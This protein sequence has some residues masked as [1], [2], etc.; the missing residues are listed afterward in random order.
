M[1][2]RVKFIAAIILMSTSAVTVK[3]DE[4]KLGFSIGSD[5]V[6]KYIWRGQNLQDDGAIQPWVEMTYGSLTGSIWGSLELSS[7]NDNAGE[8]TEVDYSLDHTAQFGGIEGVSYSIGVINY[9]FPNTSLDD[10]TEVYAGLGFE[11]F[12][13]PSVT[14]YTDVDEVEGSYVSFGIGESID[15]FIDLG[16]GVTTGL[17][18][19]A[20]LGWGSNAYNKAYWGI[21]DD[22]ANDLV[23]SLSLP[24][25]VSGWSVSPSISY[26]SLLDS[27]I[28]ATDAYDTD[29]DYIVAGVSISTSF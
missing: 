2:V 11:T 27:G 8:I 7:I 4:S 20:S 19:S 5:Y 22:G 26:I 12:L 13:N 25:E 3:A 10:T 24:F 16:N 29:S 28:R 6:S 18:I 14:I 17:E 9:S 21:E 15:E 1:S 23:I